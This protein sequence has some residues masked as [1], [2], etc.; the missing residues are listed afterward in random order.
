MF[1]ETFFFVSPSKS[2]KSTTLD[3]TNLGALYENA[4]QLAVRDLNELW[5][6]TTCWMRDY[7]AIFSSIQMQRLFVTST[8]VAA[9]E[10]N[11][12]MKGDSLL[13]SASPKFSCEAELPQLTTGK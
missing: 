9:V 10:G 2:G 11:V 7:L 4:R 6:T 5:N 1:F 8:S 3:G 13:H 12:P